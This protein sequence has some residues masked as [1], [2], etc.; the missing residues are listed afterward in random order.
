MH[1]RSTSEMSMPNR[2]A[3]S[4]AFSSSSLFS[5]TVRDFSRLSAIAYS[6]QF[7]RLKAAKR[8]PKTITATPKYMRASGMAQNPKPLTVKNTAQPKKIPARNSDKT[9]NCLLLASFSQQAI[10]QHK[11]EA[12]KKM[13]VKKPID[14]V[15]GIRRLRGGGIN[16][17]SQ[18]PIQVGRNALGHRDAFAPHKLGQGARVDASYFSELFLGDAAFLQKDFQV[19]LYAHEAH[20]LPNGKKNQEKM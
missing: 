15:S 19:R 7:Q 11:K 3:S 12:A 10:K 9:T 8:S 17:F 14:H 5:L 6:G 16:S 2:V 1:T 20:Y 18:V 13:K 4:R